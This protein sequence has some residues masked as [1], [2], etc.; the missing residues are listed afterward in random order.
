MVFFMKEKMKTEF[1]ELM[2]RNELHELLLKVID[3]F[4]ESSPVRLT[5]V[6]P[7]LIKNIFMKD[8]EKTVENLQKSFDFDVKAHPNHAESII[9]YSSIMLLYKYILKISNTIDEILK[10]EIASKESKETEKTSK[11]IL[12]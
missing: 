8:L 12:N 11:L 9:N 3:A 6:N 5:E 7:N 4:I 10:E 1:N 2:P